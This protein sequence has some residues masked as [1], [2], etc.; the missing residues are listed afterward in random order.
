MSK[1]NCTSIKQ[2]VVNEMFVRCTYIL[3]GSQ[4]CRVVR[5]ITTVD[6]GRSDWINCTNTDMD[7][8]D[9]HPQDDY[10]HRF[11]IWHEWIQV[12]NTG[13]LTFPN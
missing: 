5:V 9:L 12:S 1:A 8:A 10:T 2:L 7:L 6:P 13:L 11:F 3:R 4:S